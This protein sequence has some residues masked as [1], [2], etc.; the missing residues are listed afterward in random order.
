MNA[1]SIY[2]LARARVGD[3]CLSS[4][5]SA[6]PPELGRSAFCRGCR[7]DFDSVSV[8]SP[9]ASA[10]TVTRRP[11]SN[12][13]TGRQWVGTGAVLLVGLAL[14]GNLGKPV[15]DPTRAAQDVVPTAQTANAAPTP[16]TTPWATVKPALAPTGPTE[17]AKVVGI[18]D[19]DTIVVA[20]GGKNV[21]LRYIGMDTPED[22]DP[23]SPVEPMSREA[24][25][26]NTRLVAGKTVV[27]EKDVSGNGPV[28][29]VAALRLA[30]RRLDVGSRQSRARS[31]G[32][33][34]GR[35]V[36]A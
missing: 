1:T 5:P 14:I 12:R 27:L 32:P 25:A 28:R 10:E 24:A 35:D 9:A 20:L 29:Q 11:I 31:P 3:T 33:C 30:P 18:V 8:A 22:V 13:L 23:N 26:A 17:T 19:G 16:N 21:K 34:L 4:V 2:E 7:F 36:P 15:G 6:V